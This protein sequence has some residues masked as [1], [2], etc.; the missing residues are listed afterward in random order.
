[1]L[2]RTYLRIGLALL[3]VL[4]MSTPVSA[5]A[6][7]DRLTVNASLGPSFGN[8]GTTFAATTGLDFR[9]SDRVTLVG[10]FGMLPRASMEEAREVA[11][12]FTGEALK[13]TAYHWNGN[14]KVRPFELAKVSPYV[15]AGVGSFVADAVSESREV[16][17]ITVEDRRRAADLATNLGGGLV[18][19][20]N[21]WLGLSADYRT[22]FVHRDAED[23]RVHRFT[24]GVSFF[25]K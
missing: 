22:F 17:G 15:T 4:A 11:P 7:D 23:P 9:L 19:R 10:E 2:M 14:V 16:N 18:Y 3:T 5:Q 1:M 20:V 21:D 8:V 12:P 24:T 25:L 6:A 13:M